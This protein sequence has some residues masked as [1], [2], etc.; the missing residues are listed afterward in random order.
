MPDDVRS[1]W[2]WRLSL[3][4]S[5]L[6]LALG[7][8]EVTLL[9]PVKVVLVIVAEA[10]PLRVHCK[11]DSRNQTTAST[12]LLDQLL[13]AWP[14]AWLPA[15]FCI[16]RPRLR[17]MKVPRLGIKSELQVPAYTTATTTWDPSRV[18]NLH[19]SSWQHRIHDPLSKAGDRTLNLMDTGWIRLQWA[20]MGTPNML[21]IIHFCCLLPRI[22]EANITL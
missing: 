11:S 7:S 5:P 15:T 13:E 10:V 4:G 12:H 17:L 6:P 16:L 18:Y 21:F 20:T 9:T 1:W 2:Q 19:H 14:R 3:P 22:P 8:G